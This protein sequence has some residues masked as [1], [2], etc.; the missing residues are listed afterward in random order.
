MWKTEPKPR[1]YF[2]PPW[3]VSLDGEGVVERG[4]SSA[5]V[6]QHPV[7]GFADVKR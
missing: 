1:P 4:G 6:I 7:T 3:A 2:Y 5:V